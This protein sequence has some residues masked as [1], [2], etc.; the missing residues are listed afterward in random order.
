MINLRL[1]EIDLLLLGAAE[2]GKSTLLKQMK[3]LHQVTSD[4]TI[5]FNI[6]PYSVIYNVIFLVHKHHKR[7]NNTKFQPHVTYK[8]FSLQGG[9]RT[10]G[11][12]HVQADRVRQRHPLH[13]DDSSRR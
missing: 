2:A 11:A 3:I 8:I 13:V 6:F 4:L 5:E 9:L 1:D 12:D 7:R 10:G